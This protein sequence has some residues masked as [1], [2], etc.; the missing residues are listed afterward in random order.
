MERN[1]GKE[2]KRREKKIP[3]QRVKDG[4]TTGLDSS[5]LHERAEICSISSV[6]WSKRAWIARSLSVLMVT[7]MLWK[8]KK[9][10]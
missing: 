7:E 1:D 9:R 10:C 4:Q 2:K 8:D 3:L 5:S 6:F